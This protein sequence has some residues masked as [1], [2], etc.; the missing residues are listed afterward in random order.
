MGASFSSRQQ[1]ATSEDSSLLRSGGAVSA[2]GE[3]GRGAT[4]YFCLPGDSR[5]GS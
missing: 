4:F 1:I 3:P 2:E 5:E